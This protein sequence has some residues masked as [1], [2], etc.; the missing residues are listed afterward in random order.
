MKIALKT[1]FKCPVINTA[2]IDG[3]DIPEVM[4]EERCT[5][6]EDSYKCTRCKIYIFKEM[7]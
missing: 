7:R 5:G 6:Y 2:I 4:E 1:G 3:K